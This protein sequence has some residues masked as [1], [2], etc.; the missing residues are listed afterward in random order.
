MGGFVYATCASCGAVVVDGA[1]HALWHARLADIVPLVAATVTTL[2]PVTGTPVPAVRPTAEL[3]SVATAATLQAQ[4]VTAL[5]T[6]TTFLALATP[7]TVQAVAQVQALTRQTSA[8]IRLV[9]RAF[10]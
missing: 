9:I 7:T 2:D 10:S 1:A 6:D 3:A 8:L 4:A 5:T